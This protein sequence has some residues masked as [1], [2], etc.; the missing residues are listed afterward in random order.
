[1]DKAGDMI[2]D[3]TGGKYE[4]QIDTATEKI[5]DMIDDVDADAEADTESE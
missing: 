3:K 2:D 4:D 5:G 1:L